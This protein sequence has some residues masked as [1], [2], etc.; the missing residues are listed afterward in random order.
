MQG[1]LSSC[2]H[3]AKLRDT[4]KRQNRHWEVGRRCPNCG[5]TGPDNAQVP[6]ASHCVL[7]K[8]EEVQD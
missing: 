2:Q 4:V 8:A 1:P 3:Q 5:T 7:S 6:G